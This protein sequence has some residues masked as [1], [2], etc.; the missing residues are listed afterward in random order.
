MFL[1]FSHGCTA[2]PPDSLLFRLFAPSQ[3]LQLLQLV[4][5][6]WAASQQ[7]LFQATVASLDNVMGHILLLLASPQHAQAPLVPHAPA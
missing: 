6:E 3:E 2:R 1:R 7:D 5:Q 4:F